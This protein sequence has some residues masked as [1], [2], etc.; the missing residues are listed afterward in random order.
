M[1]IAKQ[2][3]LT[4]ATEL[5][6]PTYTATDLTP[7]TEYLFRVI[8]INDEGMSR[9]SQTSVVVTLGKGGSFITFQTQNIDAFQKDCSK[10]K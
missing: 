7:G 1:D 6:T 3:W 8:A 4:V 5:Q 10:L 9:P 2:T